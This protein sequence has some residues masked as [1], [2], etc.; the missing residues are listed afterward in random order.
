[1]FRRNLNTRSLSKVQRFRTSTTGFTTRVGIPIA[2]N[3]IV[4]FGLGAERTN[5]DISDTSPQRNQ[6]FVDEFGTT[7]NNFPLSVNWAR[8]RRDSAIYTT[9][10]T[11][12]RLFGEVSVPGGDLNYYKISYAQKW[13]YPITDT[14]TFMFNGE[15]GVG[16][17]YSGKPLPFFKNFFAGGN[18]SVRGYD[19]NSLGPRER[20]DP[21]N[22]NSRSVALGGNKR[23]VGNLEILFPIPFMKDDRSLRLSTFIDGGSVFAGKVDLN[24]MRYSAGFAISW[25]SPMGPLKISLAKPLNAKPEDNL[26]VLQ[27][28][29]G[30]RF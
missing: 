1:M 18:N 22:P 28:Q 26:Q 7:T 24:E 11:T 15:L 10:G 29:F 12:H 20:L 13:F 16:D 14:F 17:G 3:D 21:D 2:E 23:V 6:D 4:T 27:F 5:I 9:A 8:D 19:L 25:I 30:Q